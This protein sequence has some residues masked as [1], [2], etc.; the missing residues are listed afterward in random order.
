MTQSYG[1]NPVLDDPSDL[2]SSA[3]VRTSQGATRSC[4]ASDY[5]IPP[6]WYFFNKTSKTYDDVRLGVN[7]P[8]TGSWRSN[9]NRIVEVV[10]T[11][12]TSTTKGCEVIKHS[13]TLPSLIKEFNN[14]LN[15]VGGAEFLTGD[16]PLDVVT[17]DFIGQTYRTTEGLVPGVLYLAAGPTSADWIAISSG[18]G[19]S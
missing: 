13:A 1:I 19:G 15:T 9:L 6:L 5:L 2:I 7:V 18:G 11:P 4:Q 8:G 14:T 12:I 3:D 10:E 16:F 17:P